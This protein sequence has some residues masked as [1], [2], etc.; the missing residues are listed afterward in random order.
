MENTK[1]PSIL[2]VTTSI[3]P[4]Y[5]M[6]RLEQLKKF[7]RINCIILDIGMRERISIDEIQIEYITFNKFNKILSLNKILR[8]I[9]FIFKACNTIKKTS[10]DVYVIHNSYLVFIYPL[11]FRNKIFVNHT[12]TGNITS[13]IFTRNLNDFVNLKMNTWFYKYVFIISESLREK[14]KIPKSKTYVIG[15]GAKQNSLTNK[16]WNYI[17]L[18][19][20][21]TFLYRNME[22]TIIGF[23][24][25]YQKHKNDISIKYTI[26]G[27]GRK[28]EEEMIKDYINKFQ[29]HKIVE[30]LGRTNDSELASYLDFCNVGVSFVPIT[31]YFNYQPV[32]KLFEYNL[33]G[34]P[35]I[36][37]K[38]YEQLKN[39]NE[40][41]GVLI[42]DNADSFYD[43]LEELLRKKNLYS[44]NV[45]RETVEQY[46]WENI[47]QIFRD[48]IY[49]I[50]RR[51]EK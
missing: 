46:K 30:Y 29:L 1:K 34:I 20:V 50:I 32:T 5:G 4:G 45:I 6:D 7:F 16:K 36:A 42:D 48:A 47:M 28:I 15:W 22:Q 10:Y 39:V 11:L 25:F 51:E 14:L 35:V 2:Y 21:G 13:N 31:T 18:I 27:S 12:I 24:K 41:N 40:S 26:M 33:S 49:D 3:G 17:H 44:S 38:T 37:T 9:N 8:N 19:Y 23:N 43:G